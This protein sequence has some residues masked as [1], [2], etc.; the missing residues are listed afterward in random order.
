MNAA[1]PSCEQ[2]PMSQD[3]RHDWSVGEARALLELPFNDLVFRAQA[4][5]RMHFDP[6]EVQISTLLSIKTGACPEDCKY[7]PQSGHYNTGLGKEKLLEIDH[8]VA[9]A[10]AAR[11]KGASRFCM[12]A[13]WRS[14]SKKDMPYVLDMVKQVKSLGLETCMTLGMLDEG[15]AGELAEAGLDYYNH[16]LDTSE[17]YYS[18]IITTRTYADRLRT[19]DNVRTAGMKV[20]CGG[21]MGMGEDLDDR[22]GLLVQLANLPHHP[23]SVPINM[24][25]KVPGTPMENVEDLDPFEFV[26]TIAVAKILMPASHVRLSAGREQMNDQMQ[27]L[28]FLAGANSI[29]YGEKLLTTSNPEADHDRELFKRLGIRPEQ[30][31]EAHTEEER[32]AGLVT[33]VEDERNRHLFYDASSQQT[34]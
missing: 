4:A 3:L 10:R 1:A 31:D 20:C 5:H 9:Q 27:A 12:G 23:E 25:V 6:N 26:R 29:F 32:E 18:H 15:Q 33:A 13:A 8:V 14:P 19:L 34:A 28:C 17:K 2:S 24:L 22:A 7:C 11:E 21:I 30:R 16:N